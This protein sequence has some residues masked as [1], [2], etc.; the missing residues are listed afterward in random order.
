MTLAKENGWQIM[1]PGLLLEARSQAAGAAGANDDRL[2]AFNERNFHEHLVKFIV[3]N[4]Q[5][6][7]RHV[8][9]I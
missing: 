2:D 6:R 7:S 9:N 5:V 8:P 1:L 3:I 4:D